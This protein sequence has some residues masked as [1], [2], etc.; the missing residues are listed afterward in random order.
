MASQKILLSFNEE[1]I[2]YLQS[3]LPEG[4][5]VSGENIKEYIIR[6]FYDLPRNK[7][8]GRPKGSKTKNWY[9]GE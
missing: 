4:E 2:A 1:Q 6:P 9:K 8:A 5:Q 3:L 7:K